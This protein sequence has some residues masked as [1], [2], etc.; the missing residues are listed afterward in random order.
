M[1]PSLDAP[2]SARLRDATRD[3]HRRAETRPFVRDLLRG[4]LEREAYVCL[5]RDL[6]EIYAGLEAGLDALDP[7]VLPAV[8]T[9]RALRRTA[10]LAHDLEALHGADWETALAPTAAARAYRD[11]LEGLASSPTPHLLAAHAYVRYMGDLSGGQAIGRVVAKA[12]G[13]GPEA[14]LAF[15]SFPDIADVGDFKGRF[16][17]ALDAL[18]R[19]I[20]SDRM[21]EEAR[22]AFRRNGA[23]F[24]ALQRAR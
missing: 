10:M 18:G 19:R 15:Y 6:F 20:D 2:L 11:E 4:E 16:R 22:A 1:N 5:L 9:A 23:V 3:D 17:D 21:V 13:L 24:D 7:G 12:Y 8:V 14:G